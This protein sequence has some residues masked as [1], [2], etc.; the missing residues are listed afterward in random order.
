MLSSRAYHFQIS[1]RVNCGMVL[2][3]LQTMLN[4]L[5]GQIGKGC[6]IYRQHL[7]R[8]VSLPSQPVSWYDSKQSD[9][10]AL[11]MLE[12]C[13]MRSNPLL[14]PGS[15]WPRVVAPDKVLFRGQIVLNF[16]LMLNWIVWNCIV[17]I[18]NCVNK[19]LYLCWTKLFE[20]EL[21]LHLTVCK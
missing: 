12:L 5:S 17:F 1:A 14:I 11:V 9:G 18:F 2:L 20:I 16:I 10:E 21:F 19:K 15:L 7:Y 8:G 4:C 13:G 3:S 6:R